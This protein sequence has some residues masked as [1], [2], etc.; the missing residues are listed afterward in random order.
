MFYS[1]PCCGVLTPK[2]EMEEMEDITFFFFFFQLM[3]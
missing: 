3:S 2:E 1:L